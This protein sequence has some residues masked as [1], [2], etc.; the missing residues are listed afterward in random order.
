MEAGKS[1]ICR[2]GW[3]TRDQGK[4]FQFASESSLLAEFPF[5]HGRLVFLLRPSTNWIRLT[6]VLDD[7]LLHSKS[8][9]TNV[10]LT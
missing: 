6:H 7:N 9:D 5:P 8:T 3:Q 4:R 10:N 2:I 1:K